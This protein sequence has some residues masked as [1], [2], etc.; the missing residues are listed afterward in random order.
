[1]LGK[2]RLQPYPK[3]K[4]HAK[5]LL[6]RVYMDIMSS[7]VT[8]IEGYDYALVITDDASMYRWVYGLNKKSDADDAARKWVC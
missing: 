5:L 6:E 4:E 8:S 7:S 3:T 2:A 1:M